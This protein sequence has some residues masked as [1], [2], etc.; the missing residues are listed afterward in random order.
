[1]ILITGDCHGNIDIDKIKNIDDTYMTSNDYVIVCG[2]MGIIWNYPHDM[3]YENDI[4]LLKWWNEKKFTTLFIDGNH[5]NH[6]MLNSYEVS[7]FL[8]GKVHRLADKVFH[9]MRGEIYAI[10]GKTF[11]AFGGASSIEKEESEEGKTWWYEELPSLD[12]LENG[13]KNLQKFDY[14]VDYVITHAG[15]IDIV[16][17][18]FSDKSYRVSSDVLVD[19]LQEISRKI[20]F[21]KWYFGHYHFDIESIDGKF[22]CLYNNILDIK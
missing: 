8:G 18:L 2:D 3:D 13:L 16:N 22:I 12:E 6:D 7:N 17:N 1:M 9:L 5:E 11:F 19:Y 4:S 10:N 20:D 14:T 15:P 21:Q